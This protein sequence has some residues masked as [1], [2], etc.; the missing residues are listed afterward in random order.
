MSQYEVIAY[1]LKDFVQNIK[2]YFN[3]S[4]NEVIYDKRNIIKVIDYEYGRYVVKAFKVPHLL[5]QFVY[6]FFRDSKAKR[7]FLNAQRLQLMGI[8]TPQPV[9]Y[10]EFPTMF[11]FKESFYISEF[12][13]FD[14][15]IR[16]VLTDRSFAERDKILRAFAAY[17][18]KLHK[19]G[20]YH[21]D[22]SPGNILVKKEGTQYR[23]SIVDVNRMQFLDMDA[24]LRMESLAKLTDNR[25]DNLKIV[26]YYAEVSGESTDTLMGY[27]ED[28]L[29]AQQRYLE[30][31]RRWKRLLKRER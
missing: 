26:T 11:R 31:K 24:K 15:E 21:V 17:T 20:V 13:D 7:S 29:Q 28:A 9:G 4:G 5:N 23:F 2:L 1:R 8:E 3:R 18:Y 12:F 19:K 14:F 10:I 22:Y 16:A 25:E 6:R 27:L 30:R